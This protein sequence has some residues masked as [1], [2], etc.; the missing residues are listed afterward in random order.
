MSMIKS[1]QPIK[2]IVKSPG[3]IFMQIHPIFTQVNLEFALFFYF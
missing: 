1:N 2:N 3:L